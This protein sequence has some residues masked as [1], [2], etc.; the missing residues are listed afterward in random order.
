MRVQLLLLVGGDGDIRPRICGAQQRKPVLELQASTH[1]IEH[2]REMKL[3]WNSFTRCEAC[4]ACAPR[5]KLQFELTNA[6]CS[7]NS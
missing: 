6:V 5:R 2:I 1:K 3:Y 7:I 4:R